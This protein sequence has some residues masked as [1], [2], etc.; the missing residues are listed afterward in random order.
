MEVVIWELTQ[1]GDY[2]PC[3]IQAVLSVLD[4]IEGGH[5]GLT[6]R[7]VFLYNFGTDTE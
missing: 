4:N 6:E 1:R 2:E 5:L 3:C 7:G